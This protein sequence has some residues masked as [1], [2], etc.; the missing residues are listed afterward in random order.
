FPKSSVGCNYPRRAS[1]CWVRPHSSPCLGTRNPRPA[2]CGFIG[3]AEATLAL[4]RSWA[5]CTSSLRDSNRAG[6]NLGQHEG[7]SSSGGFGV[8]VAKGSGNGGGSFVVGPGGNKQGKRCSPD[9]SPDWRRVRKLTSFEGVWSKENNEPDGSAS[10]E[11]AEK[12]ETR[13]SRT[14]VC[15]RHGKCSFAYA[16]E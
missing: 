12:A 14:L 13:S 3:S 10:P 1:G 8:S 7:Q 5:A 9:S 15:A 11:R 6:R 2:T 16:S 4:P